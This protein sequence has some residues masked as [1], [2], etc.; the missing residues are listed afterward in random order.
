MMPVK[1]HYGKDKSLISSIASR[2]WRTNLIFSISSESFGRLTLQDL[3]VFLKFWILQLGRWQGLGALVVKS[4]LHG[5]RGKII[6][7]EPMIFKSWILVLGIFVSISTTHGQWSEVSITKIWL[8]C[9]G[10]LG[11]KSLKWKTNP[12]FLREAQ[13]VYL[14]K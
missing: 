9:L 3:M 10:I 11:S 8:V 13:T 12:A 6:M 5:H 1:F 2:K 14:S 4:T 7:I